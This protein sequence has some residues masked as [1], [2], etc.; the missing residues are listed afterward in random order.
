MNT[1][2]FNQIRLREEVHESQPEDLPRCIAEIKRLNGLM[3]N[4]G[5]PVL[6]RYRRQVR[7]KQSLL[8]EN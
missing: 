3:K 7:R 5:R 6:D 4:W 1:T 8:L 2:D